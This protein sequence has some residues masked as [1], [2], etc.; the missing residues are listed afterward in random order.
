MRS[1]SLSASKR[2]FVKSLLQLIIKIHESFEMRASWS[3]HQ[4][5]NPSSH[6]LGKGREGWLQHDQLHEGELSY[7]RP[8]DRSTVKAKGM[9][10]MASVTNE[11]LNEGTRDT[12][13]YFE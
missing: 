1:Q 7:S 2:S 4:G 6:K 3:Q 8:I 10:E 12:R 5:E 9:I 11:L 13:E